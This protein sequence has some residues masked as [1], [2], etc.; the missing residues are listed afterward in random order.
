MIEFTVPFG[1]VGGDFGGGG[2]FEGLASE[3]HAGG[4]GEFRE[5]FAAEDGGFEGGAGEV[6]RV[7]FAKGL[8][9]TEEIRLPRGEGFGVGEGGLSGGGEEGAKGGEIHGLG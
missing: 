1:A 9:M 7:A 5:G 2:L 6:G 8:E 4:V 3:V